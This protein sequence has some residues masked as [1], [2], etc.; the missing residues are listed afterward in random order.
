ME[1]RDFGER[2]ARKCGEGRR[3][4]EK[5]D[6]DRKTKVGRCKEKTK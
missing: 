2:E 6:N 4:E 1:I 3:R 5:E